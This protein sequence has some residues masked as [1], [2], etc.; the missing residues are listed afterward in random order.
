MLIFASSTFLTYALV[1]SEVA[2]TQK[3]CKLAPGFFFLTKIQDENEVTMK[4]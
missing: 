1:G 4:L 2:I 3:G